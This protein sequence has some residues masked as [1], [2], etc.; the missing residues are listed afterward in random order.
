LS[1]EGITI[2]AV[3]P[4]SDAAAQG[5]AAGDRVLAIDGTPIARFDDWPR[6]MP[7]PDSPPVRVT[8]AH[9]DQA[10]R[11]IRLRPTVLVP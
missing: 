8:I 11:E 5:I 6:L 7:G 9:G 2:A 4:K 1:A 3:T 10:P